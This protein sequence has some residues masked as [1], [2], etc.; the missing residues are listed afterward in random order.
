MKKSA[1]FLLLTALLFSV[2]MLFKPPKVEATGPPGKAFT[3]K[4][5]YTVVPQTVVAPAQVA[6]ESQVSPG[7]DSWA[8]E[9]SPGDLTLKESTSAPIRTLKDE[10]CKTGDAYKLSDLKCEPVIL[11]AKTW[12]PDPV[13]LE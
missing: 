11:T 3:E 4:T 8:V 9:K 1:T 6:P 7:Y 2:A 13:P 12:V 5:C 10:R